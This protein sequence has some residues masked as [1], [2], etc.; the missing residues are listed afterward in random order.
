MR[1]VQ[2]EKYQNSRIPMPL[3][4]NPANKPPFLSPIPKERL[5]KRAQI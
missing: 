2:I 1:Q 3:S 5:L 4:Q